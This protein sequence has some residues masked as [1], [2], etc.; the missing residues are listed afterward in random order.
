MPDN[1][2][3]E[4]EPFDAGVEADE[5]SDPKTYIQQLSGKLGQSLRKYNEEQP[6][7]DFKLEKFAINSVISATHTSDMDDADQNDIINKIKKSGGDK[8]DSPNEDPSMNDFKELDDNSGEFKGP[9]DNLKE[10][11]NLFVKAKKLSIFA[12]EGSEEAN[13]KG[14]IKTKLHESFTDNMETPTIEPAVRPVT[15]PTVKPSRRNRPFFPKIHPSVKPKPKAEIM[16]EIAAKKN[17]F[18]VYHNSFSSAV[19]EAETYALKN[20]YTV[21]E[22]EWW[23]EIAVGNPKPKEGE[24]N[25]YSIGLLKDGLPVKKKNLQIQIYGMR[26]KYEL[27]CYI[28]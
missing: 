16:D 20:G 15:K 1:K 24:T 10:N 3:F 25:K 28:N 27:N 17:N 9:E 12:P 14:T 21:D 7:P 13:F 11:N 2:P 22:N 26:N 8:G 19:Q 18:K 6:Q 4:K 23:N 5:D